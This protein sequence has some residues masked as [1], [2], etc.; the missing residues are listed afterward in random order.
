MDM[1]TEAI[2]PSRLLPKTGQVIS[3]VDGDDGFHQAGWWKGTKS[4]NLK[5]RFEVRT[6]GLVDVV[7]DNATGLMWPKDVAGDGGIMAISDFWAAQ[8]GFAEALDFAG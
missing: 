5:T 1:K 8:M 3:Y 6:I 4:A 7:I 2:I